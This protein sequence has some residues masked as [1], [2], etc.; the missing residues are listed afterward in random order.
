MIAMNL[1]DR[2]QGMGNGICCA[3]MDS[4]VPARDPLLTPQG[5]GVGSERRTKESS[6]HDLSMHGKL[7]LNV[8][9]VDS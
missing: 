4:Q 3:R 6:L 7:F 1:P 9:C 5:V 8:S 2:N